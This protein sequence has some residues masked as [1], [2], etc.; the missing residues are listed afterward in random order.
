MGSWGKFPGCNWIEAIIALES[1]QN[2]WLFIRLYQKLTWV[3]ITILS[4]NRR[5]EVCFLFKCYAHAQKKSQS[6]M[7][8][9]IFWK[10]IADLGNCCWNRKPPFAHLEMA[11][12][13]YSP[14]CS[15]LHPTLSKGIE[16][17]RNETENLET[18]TPKQQLWCNPGEC[19]SINPSLLP[20]QV[21]QNFWSPYW[22]LRKKMG[23]WRGSSAASPSNRLFQPC[24]SFRERF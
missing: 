17:V 2:Q 9:K 24:R 10:W 23:W 8:K 12:S 3:E 22:N 6:I 19:L 15:A 11:L 13:P 4:F 16:L 1:F 14:V 5:L 21:K 20:M 7:S 18:R